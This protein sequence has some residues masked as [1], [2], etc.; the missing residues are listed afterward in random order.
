M[1]HPP[2]TAELNHVSIAMCKHDYA[3]LAYRAAMSPT[4]RRIFEVARDAGIK[5]RS[6][7]STLA[8]VCGVSVQAVRSWEEGHTKDIRHEHVVAL[9]RY[10]RVSVHWLLTGEGD[11]N[12]ETLGDEESERLLRLWTR[13]S[14]EQRAATLV[15]LE[16][17]AKP[18]SGESRG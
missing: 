5:P 6:I 17:A 15:M 10:F 13:L 4:A 18:E 12:L 16:S 9:S 7:R 2:V 3:L 11:R 8:K 1:V 14:A